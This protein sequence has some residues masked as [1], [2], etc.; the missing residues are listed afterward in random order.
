MLFNPTAVP[1]VQ[2]RVVEVAGLDFVE[3]GTRLLTLRTLDY[4][5]TQLFFFSP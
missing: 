4:F 5:L 2:C 3:R 1:L